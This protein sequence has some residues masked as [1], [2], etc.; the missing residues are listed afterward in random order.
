[1]PIVRPVRMRLQPSEARDCAIARPMPRLAP[2]MRATL[3]WRRCCVDFLA[4]LVTCDPDTYA[5]AYVPRFGVDKGRLTADA[6]YELSI[7]V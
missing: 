7:L 2:V 3:P 1:V 4:V 5:A 6:L